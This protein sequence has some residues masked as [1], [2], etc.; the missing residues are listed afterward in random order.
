MNYSIE[1]LD[2]Y[3]KSV[4][5]AA[6]LCRAAAEA[7][8]RGSPPLGEQLRRRALAVVSHLNDRPIQGWIDAIM[9]NDPSHTVRV[10]DPTGHGDGLIGGWQDGGVQHVVD[11]GPGIGNRTAVRRTR[12]PEIGGRR[13]A[14]GRCK[15]V[16][17]EA[18]QDFGM[19][20]QPTRFG[21]DVAV[22]PTRRR[23]LPSR[24]QTQLIP[25]S[26]RPESAHRRRQATVPSSL[27]RQ[28]PR[29]RPH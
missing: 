13:Q 9:Q 14:T 25:V 12:S 27:P 2:V 18:Q 17:V 6:R 7:G 29:I 5:A 24:V 16:P 8:D 1:N 23:G 19:P 3:R 4:M 21:P 15:V 11:G 28:P 22:I 26:P 20:L 10:V